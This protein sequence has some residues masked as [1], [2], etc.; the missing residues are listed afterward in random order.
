MNN[1]YISSRVVKYSFFCWPHSMNI[2]VI[3]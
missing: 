1:I 3:H 2:N